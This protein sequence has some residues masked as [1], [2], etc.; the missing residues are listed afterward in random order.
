MT[1]EG[2]VTNVTNF[3][4]F[5]D[6]GVHQDGLVHISELSNTYISDPKTVVRAG[7]VVKVRVL[8]IDT[9]LKRVALSMKLEGETPRRGG[10]LPPVPHGSQPRRHEPR[11]TAP[12]QN[13]PSM[14]SL[15]EKFGKADGS[16]KPPLK[17]VKPV[18]SVRKLLP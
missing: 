14:Q 18:I 10:N 12:P 8:K 11:P 13:K 6:I 1:L 4:A 3:G 2:T 9:E 15:R 16:G 5:V 17:T 7:Q